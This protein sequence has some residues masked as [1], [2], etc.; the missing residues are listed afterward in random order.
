M[1]QMPWRFKFERNYAMH[2]RSA[3]DRDKFRR[4]QGQLRDSSAAPYG[5]AHARS[6]IAFYQSSIRAVDANPRVQAEPDTMI[7]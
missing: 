4:K 7:R 3:K 6:L 5:H 1:G 2:C